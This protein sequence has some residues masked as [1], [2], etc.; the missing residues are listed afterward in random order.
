[1]GAP[2]LP[3]ETP[4]NPKSRRDG[5]VLW[6]YNDPI[7]DVIILRVEILRLAFRRDDH[8]VRYPRIFV[9]D[10]AI[11]HA[12]TSDPDWDFLRRAI[13]SE[14]K[15]IGAHHNAITYG[16]A[17][18]NDAANANDASLYMPIGDDT[19]VGNNRLSQ[20]G[21]VNCAAGQKTRMRIN[22]RLGFKETVCRHKIGEIEIGFIKSADC[23]DVFPVAVENVSA[24]IAR[25]NG[26]GNYV[27]AE[28]HQIVVKTIDQHVAI[29]NV[30]AHRGL[31]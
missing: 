2:S 21:A 19:A 30:N 4:S 5:R 18:L 11:D 10:R 13:A 9:D 24:H 22:R 27:L 23:S 1:M 31:K 12:I 3:L 26:G 20:S 17:A 8:A 28:I 16:G 6:Y 14:F 25:L 29:E 7:T 15:I